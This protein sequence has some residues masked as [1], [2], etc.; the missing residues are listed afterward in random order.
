MMMEAKGKTKIVMEDQLRL[1]L[2]LMKLR[3]LGFSALPSWF[4]SLMLRSI[5]SRILS[6]RARAESYTFLSLSEVRRTS[7]WDIP[8]KPQ[9]YDEIIREYLRN[10][11]FRDENDPVYKIY[12]AIKLLKEELYRRNINLIYTVMRRMKVRADD[13]DE[14]FSVCSLGLLRAIDGWVPTSG[15]L[16][17]YAYQWI[18]SVIQ[19]YYT[20][21]TKHFA[22]SYNAH[23]SEEKEDSFEK[24][25]SVQDN[26]QDTIDMASLLSKL[27]DRE[28]EMIELKFFYNYREKE[29]AEKF[30][31][32]V[33]FV[34]LTIKRAI[35][36]LRRLVNGGERLCCPS[37]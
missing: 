14:V 15:A 6:G 24:F 2:E 20:K 16:S 4:K 21:R 26:S 5:K 19:D 18:T 35:E 23:I 28:K 31:V 22:Y 36:K 37:T 11:L 27:K 12:S 29:I 33:S 8:L 7:F 9:V 10:K 30:G 13:W 17:T 34:S 25:L 32:S 3:R 1:G